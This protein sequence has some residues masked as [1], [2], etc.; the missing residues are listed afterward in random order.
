MPVANNAFPTAGRFRYVAGDRTDRPWIT[1]R[2]NR[3]VRSLGTSSHLL[4]TLYE[5]TSVII[6]PNL[7]F[8]EW[9]HV[10]GDAK[11]I[12]SVKLHSKPSPVACER[13]KLSDYHWVLHFFI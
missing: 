9:S 5:H 4:S 7:T 11:I 12:F 1:L 13:K 10:F 3:G 2:A 6:T 8:A